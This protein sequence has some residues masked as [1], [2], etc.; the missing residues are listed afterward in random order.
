MPDPKENKPE[1]SKPEDER[2]VELGY[3]P[4]KEVDSSAIKGYQPKQPE[5][6]LNPPSGESNVEQPKDSNQPKEK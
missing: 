5:D 4:K 3:Q 2:L 6:K 1:K